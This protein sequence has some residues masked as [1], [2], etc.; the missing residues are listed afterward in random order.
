MQA[1]LGDNYLLEVT[2]KFSRPSS[3]VQLFFK[4]KAA[5]DTQDM[6]TLQSRLYRQTKPFMVEEMAKK[7]VNP[8]V[9]NKKLLSP[10]FHGQRPW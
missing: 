6:Y 10:Q 5:G 8:E 4:Q 1:K 3:N 7:V 9:F 2:K